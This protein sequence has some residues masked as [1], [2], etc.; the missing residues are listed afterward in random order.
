MSVLLSS[1]PI[2]TALLFIPVP[3]SLS[4]SSPFSDVSP[5]AVVVQ[6]YMCVCLRVRLGLGLARRSTGVQYYGGR[7]CSCH[8]TGVLLPRQQTVFVYMIVYVNECAFVWLSNADRRSL[9]SCCVCTHAA[10]QT[11]KH[12]HTLKNVS[13]KLL[14]FCALKQQ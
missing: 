6:V 10:A 7:G 8:W 5:W 1:P 14:V 9:H 4:L 3:P 13:L 12:I 2:F 11:H